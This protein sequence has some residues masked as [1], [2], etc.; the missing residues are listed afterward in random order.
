MLA[1]SANDLVT[2][3]S[4]S[5][6]LSAAALYAWRKLGKKVGALILVILAGVGFALLPLMNG[7]VLFSALLTTA[8][9]VMIQIKPHREDDFY[10]ILPMFFW[11]VLLGLGYIFLKA[12]QVAGSA[13]LSALKSNF[14]EAMKEI[15]ALFKTATEG[16]EP[17]GV[18]AIVKNLVKTHPGIA[19]LSSVVLMQSLVSYLSVRWVR[20][21]LKWVDI[22]WSQFVLFR[23][24]ARYAFFPILALLF[25]ALDPYVPQMNLDTA[26]V[27]ILFFFGGACLLAGLGAAGFLILAF[28][29]NEK[30]RLATFLAVGTI[31]A[32]FVAPQ[33]FVILGLIDIWFDVRKLCLI[34]K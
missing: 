1:L 33:G 30:N 31:V 34:V 25:L 4:L 17:N 23:V 11:A 29:C 28:R 15:S 2:M 12:D 5:G 6:I 9:A 18:E 32:F 10:F 24:R 19:L 16:T 22:I 8:A 7:V 21:R 13:A 3:V 20:W 14:A 26:S 27:P